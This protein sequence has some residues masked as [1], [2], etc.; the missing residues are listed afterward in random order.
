MSGHKAQWRLQDAKT[1]F[2]QVVD[3]ALNGEVQH[4]TRR[5]KEAVVVLSEASYRALR[6]SARSSAPGFITHLLAIPKDDGATKGQ[7]GS[8]TRRG[9]R[10]RDIDL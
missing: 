2:S 8:S 10:L 9:P 6:D 1:Q 7:S 4:V 5:G 3:A